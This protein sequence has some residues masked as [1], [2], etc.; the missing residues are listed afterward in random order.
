M[1]IGK[2]TR[3]LL[4][5]RQIALQANI[6]VDKIAAEQRKYFV[7]MLHRQTTKYLQNM[8]AKD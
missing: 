3:N 4:K 8:W 6:Q 7:F 5:N 1:E 2:R